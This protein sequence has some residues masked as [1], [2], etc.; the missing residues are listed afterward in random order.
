[1]KNKYLL[2]S[3]F[4][5]LIILLGYF[6][7]KKQPSSTE[8]VVNTVVS[9]T[10]LVVEEV[11]QM[12]KTTATSESGVTTKEIT[13]SYTNDGFSPASITI[14]KDSTVVFV[15][16]SD[17][18]MWVASAKHP[19]HLELPGFDQ[20]KGSS[21]GEKYSYTFAKVGKWSFHN[22]LAPGDTGVIV[23]E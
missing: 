3:V 1:M 2:L 17:S 22:H 18:Q 6:L 11:T 23:V 15:N 9:P 19:I 8:V 13:V 21:K 20:L 12:P 5:V 10:N 14:K 4:A 7:F 16:N